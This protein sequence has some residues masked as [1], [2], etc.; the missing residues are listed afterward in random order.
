[1]MTAYR[2]VSA[3][4][5]AEAA[6]LAGLIDGE[7]T[8]GLTR[9]HRGEERQ[10]VISISNT[11]LGLLEYVL[12]TIGAGRITTKRTYK[13]T[14]SRSF[15]FAIDNRQALALLEQVSPYLRT[16]KSARAQLVLDH[17]V[18]LTPRNGRYTDAM[19]EER[20]SFENRFLAIR[21]LATIH[22]EA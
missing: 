22:M 14:H 13:N 7:G 21:P 15:T 17:Y 8:I 18:K 19:K 2:T 4:S 11:E 3:L 9:R 6:Y 12:K 5:A 20:H 10:L 1:M 16:Y